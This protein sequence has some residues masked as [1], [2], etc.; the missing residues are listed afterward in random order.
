MGSPSWPL[1]VSISAVG[2][3]GNCPPSHLHHRLHEYALRAFEVNALDYLLKPVQEN[4]LAAAL[5]KARTQTLAAPI[6]LKTSP[7]PHLSP[8]TTKYS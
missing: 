5:D 6:L 4:R 3:Q 2:Q 8:P 7:P 1:T